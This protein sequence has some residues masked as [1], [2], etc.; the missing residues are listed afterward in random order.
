MSHA[1][2]AAQTE[3]RPGIRSVRRRHGGFTLIELLVVIAIIAI[4]AS[5]LL[6]ALAKAKT[7]AKSL[8][9]L[10]NL[11]Q[12]GLG[13]QLYVDDN[14]DRFPGHSSLKS[15]TTDLGKPRTR[16]A[17]AIFPYLRIEK[18]YLSPNLTPEDRKTMIKPFAHTVAP[19]LIETAETIYFGGYGFNYQYLGN[20]RQPGGIAPYHAR[21]TELRATSGTL[22]L[23]DTKGARAGSPANDYGHKGS[24]V[25]VLDPPLGSV[26][27]G[28]QGSRSTSAEPGAGN[29]Y[30]EGGSD[31]SDAHRATPA[32]R[33]GGRVNLVFVDGHAESLD[34]AKLDGR[35]AG[36]AG[37]P[38]N[39]LW[40]GAGDATQR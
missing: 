13:M 16:W 27:L 35:G 29:A 1:A 34:P 25:Y 2:F 5:M 23:G 11:R 21:S 20:N 32:A 33:N 36:T 24:A 26:Q 3:A 12:L 18:A 37:V 30:Y 28:A 9:S 39:A 6:P 31:G 10:N 40:N 8:A 4:L 17:D 22:C 38:N 14:D 19:G 15:E 7:K